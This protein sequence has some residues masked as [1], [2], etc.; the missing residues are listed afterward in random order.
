MRSK[1][2]ASFN[3]QQLLYSQIRIKRKT[4]CQIPN[5]LK[6]YIFFIN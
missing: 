1:N 2:I 4:F 3:F 6:L 5:Q